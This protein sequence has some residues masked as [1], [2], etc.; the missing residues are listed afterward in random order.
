MRRLILVLAVPAI[1]LA[2]CSGPP[3]EPPAQPEFAELTRVMAQQ[4]NGASCP[5]IPGTDGVEHLEVECGICRATPG[6]STWGAHQ[7]RNGEVKLVGGCAHLDE[8]SCRPKEG[9]IC[10]PYGGDADPNWSEFFHVGTRACIRVGTQDQYL[11]TECMDGNKLKLIA[12]P[13]PRTDER[14]ETVLEPATVAPPA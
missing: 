9:R 1:A 14:C 11:L 10:A 6:S 12:G 4:A 5:G 3:A 7:C 8:A 2:S 13:I